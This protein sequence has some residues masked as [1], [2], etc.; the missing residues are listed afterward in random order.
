MGRIVM[1]FEVE[2]LLKMDNEELGLFLK[3]Y[4]DGVYRNYEYIEYKDD[5]YIY[6]AK[7]FKKKINGLE[8]HTLN[9]EEIIKIVYKAVLKYIKKIMSTDSIAI[10]IISNYINKKIKAKKDYDKAYKELAKLSKTIEQLNYNMEPNVALEILN[11]NEVLQDLIKIIVD[12]DKN[13]YKDE[14]IFDIYDDYKIASFIQTYCSKNNIEQASKDI[15]LDDF[16]INDDP[17]ITRNPIKQYISEISS[18]PLLTIEEEQKL[19]YR[20][21]EGD[22]EAVKELTYHNLKLAVAVA[23]KYSTDLDKFLDVIQS[24]NEG[25][26]IAATKY[27]VTKGFRFSTY[28]V[29]W[30]RQGIR[31]DYYKNDSPIKIPI[32]VRDKANNMQKAIDRMF[33]ENQSEPNIDE[34]AD[35]FH[36][37]KRIIV[38]ILSCRQDIAS[39]QIACSDDDITTLQDLIEDDKTIGT[40]DEGIKNTLNELLYAWLD[41]TLS[42]REKMVITCRFG[43]DGKGIR[44]L[45]EISEILNIT[46]EYVRVI[47]RIS[48]NKLL[49]SPDANQFIDYLDY[50]EEARKK[51]IEYMQKSSYKTNPY[52]FKYELDETRKYLEM[53]NRVSNLLDTFSNFTKNQILT[54]IES[55][56][57]EHKKIINLAYEDNLL[58]IKELLNSETEDSKKIIMTIHDKIL[59]KINKKLSPLDSQRRVDEIIDKISVKGSKR[60]RLKNSREA[61][62]Q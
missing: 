62:K 53:K 15:E 31:L 50:P 34:L 55:L 12:S 47:E 32:Q 26:I 39:L 59:P 5:L 16:Y 9:N 51:R 52:T 33:I 42:D 10:S 27:D 1:I 45:R 61:I 7:K 8:K 29:H 54:A 19:G 23:K 58:M 57:A 56:S 22:K 18:I 60:V 11:K 28:A 38:Q 35:Y 48:I 20:I 41:K 40:E 37:S 36:A 17:Y 24:A 4:I 21:L 3:K 30:I 14:D 43:L 46:K 2:D 25:L 49:K 13:K 6:V 44:T